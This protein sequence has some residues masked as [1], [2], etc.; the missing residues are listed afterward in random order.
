MKIVKGDFLFILLAVLVACPLYAAEF[1]SDCY[2]W[3]GWT[4]NTYVGGYLGSGYQSA[5]QPGEYSTSTTISGLGA[6]TDY[7][8]WVRGHNVVGETSALRSVITA[9]SG[10]DKLGQYITHEIGFTADGWYWQKAGVIHT[11]VG[12]TSVDYAIYQAYPVANWKQADEVRLSDN[13]SY[14]PTETKLPGQG[15]VFIDAY[16]MSGWSSQSYNPYHSTGIGAGN[17]ATTDPGTV[18]A[19]ED[20]LGGFD[21]NMT[22][23]VWAR[24]GLNEDNK[25]RGINIVIEGNGYVLGSFTTHND[26]YGSGETP[27]GSDWY[28]ARGGS[29]DTGSSAI[30]D[31]TVTAAQGHDISA[32]KTV[33][34]F[35]FTT[36]QS[37]RPKYGIL[38][39]VQCGD[40]GVNYMAGDINEDCYVDILDISLLAEQWLDCTNV[41]DPNCN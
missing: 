23:Y 27:S 35:L 14:E 2:N 26:P 5:Y 10:A 30:L 38:L 19:N 24:A 8:V 3:T 16:H 12:T 6:D 32:W 13:L 37:Y 33:D 18:S 28:W 1:T 34:A 11:P 20:D 15:S 17:T 31:I 36:D 40:A 4:Q 39:D 29:F 41:A 25:K 9:N 7:V 22:Y 21:P